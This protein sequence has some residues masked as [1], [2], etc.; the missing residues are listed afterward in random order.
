M[1]LAGPEMTHVDVEPPL[2][3]GVGGETDRVASGVEA[4]EVV[5]AIGLL[6]DRA[7]RRARVVG[8]Q[9]LCVLVAADVRADHELTGPRA[10]VDCLTAVRRRYQQPGAAVG[11]DA[12]HL[13]PAGQVAREKPVASA[14]VVAP[15][16]R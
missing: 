14:R 2:V 9:Q 8:I 4:A 13:W 11:A 1:N 7:P 12:P 3:T 6:G 10:H 5:D 15:G 16:V